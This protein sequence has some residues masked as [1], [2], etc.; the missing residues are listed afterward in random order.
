MGNVEWDVRFTNPKEECL[1]GFNYLEGKT[2]DVGEANTD[3]Q[4]IE[5]G[6]FFIKLS[7]YIW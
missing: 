7:I 2:D 4:I 3:I 5:F 1:I 6:L